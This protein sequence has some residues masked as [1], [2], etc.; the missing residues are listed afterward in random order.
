MQNNI[1]TLFS[2]I[3]KKFVHIAKTGGSSFDEIL[4]KGV[5]GVHADCI[6]EKVDSQKIC[7]YKRASISKHL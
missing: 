2:V 1:N 3:F 5:N 7:F 6:I 4:K